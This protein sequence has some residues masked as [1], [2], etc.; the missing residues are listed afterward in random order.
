VFENCP[1][2]YHEIVVMF[3]KEREFS[4]YNNIDKRIY[5]LVSKRQCSS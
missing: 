2:Y 1:A 5:M 3:N 4:L